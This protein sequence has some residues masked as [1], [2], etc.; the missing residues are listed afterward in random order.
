[1]VAT[2]HYQNQARRSA[3]QM[4]FFKSTTLM[5]VALTRYLKPNTIKTISR[6]IKT[7]N[8]CSVLIYCIATYKITDTKESPKHRALLLQKIMADGCTMYR[9]PNMSQTNP[10]NTST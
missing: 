8:S 6:S 5:T 3:N 7:D 2:S 9:V 4:Q 1:M 10:V